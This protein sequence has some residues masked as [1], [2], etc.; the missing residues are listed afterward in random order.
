MRSACCRRAFVNALARN[1]AFPSNFAG[2][3]VQ[4]ITCVCVCVCV[5]M[6]VCHPQLLSQASCEW[7]CMPGYCLRRETQ[8][9]LLSSITHKLVHAHMHKLPLLPLRNKPPGSFVWKGWDHFGAD[10]GGRSKGFPLYICFRVRLCFSHFLPLCRS[11]LLD[12]LN[13]GPR[14]LRCWLGECH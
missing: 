13:S 14:R 12:E 8:L 2:C 11:L 5:D 9:C 3:A 1:I 4:Y 6:R 10:H 7:I